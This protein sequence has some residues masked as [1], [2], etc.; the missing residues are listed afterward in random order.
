MA[1]HVPSPIDDVW[2]AVTEPERLAH[3]NRLVAAE[4]G[5]DP[6]TVDFADY[7]PN[8]AFAAHYRAEFS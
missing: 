3:L 2:A 4:N 7:H 5:A 8:E 1:A 6:A